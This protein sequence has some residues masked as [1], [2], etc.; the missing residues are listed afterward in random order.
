MS[1]RRLIQTTQLSEE[2]LTHRVAFALKLAAGILCFLYVFPHHCYPGKDDFPPSTIM[3]PALTTCN[4]LI[5]SFIPIGDVIL[6]KGKSFDHIGSVKVKSVASVCRDLDDGKVE[7]DAIVSVL[8]SRAQ[9][10]L[11]NSYVHAR[12]VDITVVARISELKQ[13]PAYAQCVLTNG[14]GDKKRH[15]TVLDDKAR[16]ISKSSLDEEEE[17]IYQDSQKGVDSSALL[18]DHDELGSVGANKE[19]P[20]SENTESEDQ[21]PPP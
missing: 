7:N 8:K 6:V 12:E 20:S 10:E 5:G 4:H 9:Q 13:Q 11:P 18:S 16:T 21:H 3:F 15:L 2:D 17:A 1:S 14:N 19:P